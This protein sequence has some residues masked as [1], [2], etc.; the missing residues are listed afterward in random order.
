MFFMR[1]FFSH[2]LPLFIATLLSACT[3]TLREP[4]E[5]LDTSSKS[6]TLQ[7]GGATRTFESTAAVVRDVLREQQ[8]TLGELDRVTPGE[9]S[10]VIDG[11]TI[12]VVRVREEFQIETI[13]IPFEQ[14]VV[15]NEGLPAGER[16]L[17][18]TG[19][20]GQEEITYRI[21][22]EDG[23]QVSRV[24]VR[25]Q[26]LTAARPEITMLG[27]QTNLTVVPIVG[28]LVY[29]SAGNAWQVVE[30]SGNRAPLTVSGDLD[31]R[32]FR[33]S[34][35]GEYL[36]YSRSAA[37]LGGFNS[38]W[39]ISTAEESTPFEL[40]IENILWADW[41]PHRARTLAF[42]T[43]EPRSAAPGW[44]AN[45]DLRLMQFDENNVVLEPIAEIVA[46]NAGGLMGWYGTRFAWAADGAYISYAQ[47]DSM[48][49]ISVPQVEFA[50][51]FDYASLFPTDTP[52]PFFAT[53]TP[54][55]TATPYTQNYPLNSF[56]LA[57]YTPYNTRSDWVWLPEMQ[58]SADNR[59][60]FTV[61][62]GATLGLEAPEDSAVFNLTALATDGGFSAELQAQA[63][64][65][66]SPAISPLN[67][68]A[69]LAFLQADLPLESATS[70]YRLWVADVDGSNPRAL[71]PPAEQNGLTPQ[72]LS[73]SPDGRLVACLWDGN[74]WVV[75]VESGQAQQLSSDGETRVVSWSGLTEVGEE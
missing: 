12:L 72:T 17:L 37:S 71:F 69:R 52:D 8:V 73:W 70:R 3:I 68:T 33:L 67:T 55:P 62:H 39:A 9:F 13:E 66:A 22:Y 59:I 61:L 51:R 41:A 16:R 7:V 29:L 26:T 46:S 24:E 74:L 36:L 21:V 63:G 34:P 44:K 42:S 15:R 64:M 18:Q 10:P 20:N 50:P 54:L 35:D 14:Q 49:V 47:A 57:R 38:L 53:A 40:G 32:I 75:D 58:W 28:R 27:V 11:L 60:L 45:N 1:R 19:N 5:N 65:W 2:I 43:A 23:V 30:D 6:V 25:R 4:V 31:G 56:V 48:G